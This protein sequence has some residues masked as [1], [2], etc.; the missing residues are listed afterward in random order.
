MLP[1][2]GPT[3][4]AASWLAGLTLAQ[5]PADIDAANVASAV[6]PVA[7]VAQIVDTVSPP[8]TLT[9]GGGHGCAARML[10]TK[11]PPATPVEVRRNCLRFMVTI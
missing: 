3:P 6:L 10:G 2:V 5:L 1:E 11:M 8:L 9:I 4:S 7:L